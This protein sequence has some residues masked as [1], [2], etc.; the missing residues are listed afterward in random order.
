MNTYLIALGSNLG[1]RKYYIDQAIDKISSQCGKVLQVAEVIESEPLGAADQIFCNTVLMA[2]TLLKP[3]ELLSALLKIE[4]DLGRQRTVHWGNRTIDLDIILWN[5]GLEAKSYAD[6]Q[7][8]IPHPE[9]LNRDFVLGP[10]AAIAGTWKH[11]TDGRTLAEIKKA[12][13]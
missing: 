11:P 5:Q 3:R 1:D 9:A 2:E 12:T 6:E 10:A 7:L 8:T 13:P 4:Q